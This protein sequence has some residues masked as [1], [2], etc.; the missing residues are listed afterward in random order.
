VGQS[1]GQLAELGLLVDGA[2]AF[3]DEFTNRADL[4][5]WRDLLGTVPPATRAIYFWMLDEIFHERKVI[6]YIVSSSARRKYSIAFDET[7]KGIFDYWRVDTIID[8]SKNVSRALGICNSQYDVYVVHLVR[9]PIEFL[10]SVSKRAGAMTTTRQYYWV[11]HWIAKNSLACLLKVFYRKRYFRLN[12]RTLYKDPFNCLLPLLTTIGIE[13]DSAAFGA[14][15][16]DLRQPP[17]SV[18]GNR[19]RHLGVFK[20]E[21]K[22]VPMDIQRTFRRDIRAI[23]SALNRLIS[24]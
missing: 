23:C 3:T 21:P 7:V 19:I 12:Y 5:R 10:A 8:S 11:L 14:V 2:G 16:T 4:G 20:L 22:E 18:G 13:L 1:C 9:N 6:K 17:E 24:L 15:V